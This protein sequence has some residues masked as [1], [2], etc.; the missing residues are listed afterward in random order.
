MIAVRDYLPLQQGL[1][2]TSD[3]KGHVVNKV[4]DYLPLQ[5]GLRLSGKVD[6]LAV[7]DGQRLSSI[8]TRIKTI[9]LLIFSVNCSHVRDYLPLQQGLRLKAPNGVLHNATRSQRLSS[10]TTRIKTSVKVSTHNER[11]MSETIFHYNKD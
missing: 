11:N 10:I 5:Q 3:L 1:R 4:R 2:Q 6:F 8:T 7:L 9:H